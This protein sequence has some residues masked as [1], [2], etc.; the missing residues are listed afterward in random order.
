MLDFNASLRSHQ[1]GPDSRYILCQTCFRLKP[2]KIA[3][4]Y[5][6]HTVFNLNTT[7]LNCKDLDSWRSLQRSRAEPQKSPS[8]ETQGQLVGAGKGLN[9]RGK[10]SSEESQEREDDWAEKKRKFSGTNQ[11]LELLRPFGTSP[12]KPCP[13]G[14]FLSFLTFFRPNFFLARSDFSLPLLT[15]PGSPRIQK[16]LEN[17]F[18]F[19]LDMPAILRESVVV[20]RTRPRAIP[21]P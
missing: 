3:G 10:N 2:A 20:V 19:G 1:C 9:G 14:L 18:S 4:K 21:F 13:Q 16:T 15:A 7:P 8:S 6:F 5:I 17:L 11:R 12:L